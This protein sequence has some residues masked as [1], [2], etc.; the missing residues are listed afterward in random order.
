MGLDFLFVV[1]ELNELKDSN[2]KY[3]FF[4][5]VCVCR[6]ALLINWTL[7]RQILVSNIYSFGD[8]IK[9]IVL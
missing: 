2:Y 1:Q 9:Y 5:C 7:M 6:R 3:S 8:I 4:L